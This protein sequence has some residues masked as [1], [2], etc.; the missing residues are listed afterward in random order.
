MSRISYVFHSVT[1]I[2]GCF[3]GRPVRSV[4]EWA[5]FFMPSSQNEAMETIEVTDIKTMCKALK[6]E[7]PEKTDPQAYIFDQ[8]EYDKIFIELFVYNTLYYN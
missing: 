2:S 1:L 7:L 6:A 3:C 4:N 5:R 8:E